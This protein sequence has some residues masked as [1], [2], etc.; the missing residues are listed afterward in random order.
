M[1]HPGLV[2]R[3]L[4]ELAAA[5]AGIAASYV[6]L[7]PAP[8]RSLRGPSPGEAGRPPARGADR[9]ATSIDEEHAPGDG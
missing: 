7:W 5:R 8:E 3:L 4:G 2:E 1:T 9:A 6:R